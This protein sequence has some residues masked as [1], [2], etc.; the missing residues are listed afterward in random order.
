MEDV[1]IIGDGDCDDGEYNTFECEY[2]GGDCDS[3]NSRYPDCKVED[4]H[5]IGDGD[6]DGG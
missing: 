2:D 1:H 3:F 5:I 4:V 6:C